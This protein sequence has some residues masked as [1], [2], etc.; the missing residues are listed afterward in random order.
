MKKWLALVILFIT[1]V[2]MNSCSYDD[3]NDIDIITPG[4]T[5]KTGIE[6]TKKLDL[7]VC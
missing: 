5:T 1:I 4:D 7:E 6:M 3:S 2:G